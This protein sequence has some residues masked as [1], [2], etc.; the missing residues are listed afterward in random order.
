MKTV[1]AVLMIGFALSGCVTKKTFLA[2]ETELKISQ[3]E[4]E[5]AK[6]LLDQTNRELTDQKS[7]A[8]RLKAQVDQL[9]QEVA[10]KNQ[11]SEILAE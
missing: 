9:N 4:L 8:E 1:L 10:A 11:Q 3:T 6:S 5:K 7:A 2:K